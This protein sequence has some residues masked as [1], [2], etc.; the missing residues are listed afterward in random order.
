MRSQ[1]SFEPHPFIRP[2]SRSRVYLC[3]FRGHQSDGNSH[4]NILNQFDIDGH[5]Y[6]TADM[7]LAD[8]DGNND[9]YKYHTLH[10]NIQGLM[11]SLN[12]LENLIST[13]QTKHIHID[14]IL[15]CETFLHGDISENHYQ[16][17]GYEFVCTNRQ[18]KQKG[19]VGIYVNSKHKYTFRHDM[20]TFIEGEY[21]SIFI[22]VG[23]KPNNLLVGEIYRIPKTPALV[24]V[25]RYEESISKLL[26]DKSQDIIV[27]SYQNFDY[28]KINDHTHTS[29]LFNA[30]I[31]NGLVPV[32]TK[33]TRIT[34]NTATLIDN[35]YI[36][37]QNT[38]LSSGIITTEI[39]DH[40]PIF[41]FY[42][43]KVKTKPK[44]V[45]RDTRT[46]NEQNIAMIRNILDR[47]DLDSN[48]SNDTLDHFM[49]V[50]TTT[51]DAIAP[52][53]TIKIHPERNIRDPWVTP[54]IMK[55]AKTLDKM[56]RKTIKK[57]P[58]DPLVTE[59]KS[60][61]NL[62][63]RVRKKAKQYYYHNLFNRYC[64]DI[65]KTW[66]V[67]RSIIKKNNDK[68]SISDFQN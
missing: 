28:L 15:V 24:S 46:L 6:E 27:G 56:F 62:L 57:S 31:S 5:Y 40:L 34:H 61:R 52:I 18:V 54:G 17:L 41:S 45:S 42:G 44:P 1:L 68:S 9:P 29:D 20:S 16:L 26:R 13:L 55:S 10:I 21:E 33:P 63:N 12:N 32:I 36:K 2:P 67:M 23:A 49:N 22:E 8:S 38:R 35:I 37:L 25:D 4:E 30:F 11:S 64:N 3:P 7:N 47:Y 58:N 59:Y 53:K 14:F 65:R 19:G 50:M 39:F 48:D 51:I 60:Y 66:E 43:R